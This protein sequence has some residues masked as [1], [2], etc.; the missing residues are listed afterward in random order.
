MLIVVCISVF[1]ALG[2]I[3]CGADFRSDSTRQSSSELQIR[4]SLEKMNEMLATKDLQQVMSVYDASDDIVVVGS[5]SGEVYVGR[6]Q[7]QKFMKMIISMPFVFSFELEPAVIRHDG[8]YAWVFTD[9][10]MIHTRPNGK[11]T[12]VPYRITAVMVKRESEWK[13]KM[14]SGSIPRG[15]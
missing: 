10:T 5:D 13:W 2:S 3:A 15:E 4:K 8:N 12:R 14:F 1:T 9:G 6:E 11:I 7:V